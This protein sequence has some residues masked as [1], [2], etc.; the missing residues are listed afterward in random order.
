MDAQSYKGGSRFHFSK[1]ANFILTFNDFKDEYQ[2][3]SSHISDISH[4]CIKEWV[5]EFKER[6]LTSA[7]R[8]WTNKWIKNQIEL[9]KKLSND[10]K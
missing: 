6:S 9:Y 2:M 3:R 10:F 5:P 1:I 4:Y 8:A 7:E